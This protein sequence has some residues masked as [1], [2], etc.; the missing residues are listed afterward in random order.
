MIHVF[1]QFYFLFSY[2]IELEGEGDESSSDDDSVAD[3]N[4]E[5]S[6][7]ELD[8]SDDSETTGEA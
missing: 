7:E 5:P 4:F 6:S 8:E 1:V 3:A 2:T